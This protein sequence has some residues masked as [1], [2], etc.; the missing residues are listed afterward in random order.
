MTDRRIRDLQNGRAVVVHVS[1]RKGQYVDPVAQWAAERELLTYCGDAVRYTGH[2]RSP[3]FNPFKNWMKS[4]HSRDE[5]C[6]LFERETLPHLDVTPLMGRA[7]GCWCYPDRCHC[8]ALAEKAN[9][10]VLFTHSSR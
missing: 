9:R 3:W 6:E 8:D 10:T 5:V 1:K 7:L 4:G 2:E